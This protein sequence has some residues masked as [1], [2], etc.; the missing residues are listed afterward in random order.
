MNEPRQIARNVKVVLEVPVETVRH[1]RPQRGKTDPECAVILLSTSGEG[2]YFAK[3]YD[4]RENSTLISRG[5]ANIKTAEKAAKSLLDQD[6]VKQAK[7]EAREGWPEYFGLNASIFLDYEEASTSGRKVPVLILRDPEES[8]EEGL[9][10]AVKFDKCPGDVF[11]IRNLNDSW[12]RMVLNRD[13]GDGTSHFLILT[14]TS[15]RS[16]VNI[17]HRTIDGANLIATDYILTDK[18]RIVRREAKI[19][20][21]KW[22]EGEP[23]PEVIASFEE[24]APDEHSEEESV[25][26]L[27]ANPVKPTPVTPAAAKKNGNRVIV[28]GQCDKENTVK[29]TAKTAHCTKC[30]TVLDLTA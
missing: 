13:K 22:L 10:T 21:E 9:L 25:I 27:A 3:I 1:F 8:E 28:C 26:P 17:F 30:K 23:L 15:E 4:E 29:K 16:P 6:K 11:A 20:K 2:P 24:E 14:V 5:M 12:I 19:T 18:R 7:D